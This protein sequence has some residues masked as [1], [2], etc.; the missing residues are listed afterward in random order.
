MKRPNE[1]DIFENHTEE[2]D[3]EGEI[4]MGNVSDWE[5]MPDDHLR[6]NYV[7]DVY[8]LNIYTI[9]YKK[10]KERGIK[11]ITFDLDETI[12]PSTMSKPPKQAIVLF[13][14]LRVDMGF[15][16]ILLSNNRDDSKVQGVAERMGVKGISNAHKPAIEQFEWL[17][18]EY[19]LE[20]N[21]M[22]HVGNSVMNDVAGGN[23]YGITTCLV[24]LCRG[25]KVLEI[26]EGLEKALKKRGIWYKHHKEQKN[27]QYY[28]LGQK[29]YE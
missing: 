13:N 1:E 6:K 12:A 20:K 21:Q 19:K 5:T 24:R 2:K 28:Q 14:N 26:D 10:L 18:K 15:E 23:S 16:V 22:A 7:P 4:A 3:G 27:D 8:Q 17:R 11:L 29:Q 25:K 9:E